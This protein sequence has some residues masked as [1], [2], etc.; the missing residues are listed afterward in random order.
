MI[1]AFDMLFISLL[2]V[3]LFV[4][5]VMFIT[6]Y[7]SLDIRSEEKEINTNQF[8]GDLIPFKLDRSTFQGEL[9]P[10]QLDN[11][12]SETTKQNSKVEFNRT[13]ENIQIYFHICMISNW[14]PVIEKSLKLIESSG[15]LKIVTNINIVC[16]GSS[17]ELNKLK[18][19]ID[20]NPKCVLRKH[21]TNVGLY[22]RATLNVLYDDCEK[23]GD[24]FKA[25]YFHSKG[26]TRK[27]GTYDYNN[28]EDWVNYLHYFNIERFRECIFM[29][30]RSDVCGVN[31]IT[32]PKLHYSGNFWWANSNYIKTLEREI[33][34]NYLDPEMWVCSSNPI[35]V[36]LWQADIF[37]Y[38]IPYPAHKYV[39]KEFKPYSNK[40]C[41]QPVEKKHILLEN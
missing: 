30:D 37:H 2:I 36:T 6:M 15:L 41:R 3:S 8:Q 10:F 22:E 31:L 32:I 23:S 12:L 39:D 18:S 29:L 19:I 27:K 25:L 13:K 35:A 9:I 33:D 20:N 26:I 21:D 5:S 16:L 14:K 28:I 34:D 11:V 1:I 4:L 7:I 24:N 38:E 17:E 40:C